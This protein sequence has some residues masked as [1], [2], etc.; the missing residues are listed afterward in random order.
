MSVSGAC[1]SF[2]APIAPT[3]AAAT[4][5]TS[6]MRPLTLPPRISESTTYGHPAK[7]A[8]AREP[9]GSYDRDGEHA[10]DERFVAVMRAL[11]CECATYDQCTNELCNVREPV[12]LERSESAQ[13]PRNK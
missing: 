2:C 12:R 6:H 10:R 13:T 8:R 1:G 3:N 4:M 7:R 5:S 11:S 9:D